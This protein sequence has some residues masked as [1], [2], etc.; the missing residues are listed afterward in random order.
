MRLVV[1]KSAVTGRWQCARADWATKALRH[2][3]LSHRGG[4]NHE[5][6][7]IDT[8]EIAIEDTQGRSLPRSL[9]NPFDKLR[10]GWREEGIGRPPA[11]GLRPGHRD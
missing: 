10:T 7:R 5:V 9:T 3:E 1:D 11:A 2:E 4:I 8:K 6:T